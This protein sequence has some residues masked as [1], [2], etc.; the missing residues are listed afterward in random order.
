MRFTVKTD[1][2][3]AYHS[4]DH[5]D[6][7]HGGAANDNSRNPHF[8][9]RLEKLF[10]R[11]VSVLDIGCAGGGFVKSLLDDGHAAVG[12]EGSDYCKVRR[13]FEWATVPGNLFTC[14]AT[15][16]FAVECDGVPALFDVVTCWEVM[17]HFLEEEVCHVV[18]NVL[19]HLAPH[20]LWAMSVSEQADDHFHRCVRP[21]GWWVEKFARDG[22]EHHPEIRTFFEPHWV[23]G[24]QRT[25]WAFDAPQSFHLALKRKAL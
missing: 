5:L 1:H 9:R 7:L 13:K 18:D 6:A 8:N 2:P 10:G 23:R 12:L 11:K 15:R 4:P 25:E 20:G 14:D 21:M 22:L 19:R 16:P 3:V 17:E 24:P